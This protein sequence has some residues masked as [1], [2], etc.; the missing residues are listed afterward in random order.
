MEYKK[1]FWEKFFSHL[2]SLPI[3]WFPLPII[4][5]LDVFIEFYHQ[6][7]FPLYEIPKVKR[8][9]YIQI[10]DRNKLK[11]LNPL[12]KI[13][14]MYCGYVNGFFP[15]AKE[16]ANRTEKYWCGI[17]H[18]NKPGFKAQ[19]HQIKQ[20]FAKFDNEKDFKKKYKK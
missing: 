3:I 9:E 4:I 1:L 7:C 20:A 19:T 15:Y 17:I 11:Y 6:T 14:C 18:E 12:E 16:I 2:I 10:I 8:S 13:G 5:V